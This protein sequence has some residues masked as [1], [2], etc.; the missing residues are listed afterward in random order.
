MWGAGCRLQ[1]LFN[2]S[3]GQE[4]LISHTLGW[5][6]PWAPS[7]LAWSSPPAAPNL[8]VPPKLE[9]SA[10][11]IERYE[12]LPAF[13]GVIP[14]RCAPGAL[15]RAF[16]S[17][18]GSL[19]RVSWGSSSSVC[20]SQAAWWEGGARAG[21]EGG[22]GVRVPQ[23]QTERAGFFPFYFI[24]FLFPYLKEKKYQNN[25]RTL[26]GTSKN[27]IRPCGSSP[28]HGGV[29]PRAWCLLTSFES[30]LGLAPH[31]AAPPATFLVKCAWIGL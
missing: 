18:R 9:P 14:R 17:G 20:Q 28:T 4:T 8:A 22:G 6:P 2:W 1:L 10:H 24:F 5:R 21:R 19:T 12:E 11:P 29:F 23:P 3:Q 13:S 27:Q 16:A 26:K 15:Q 25:P 7:V 30:A 31:A